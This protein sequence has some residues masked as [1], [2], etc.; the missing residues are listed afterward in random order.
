MATDG[1][2]IIFAEVKTRASRQ[3]GDPLEAID[4]KKIRHLVH[5]ADAY[6][7]CYYV[8]LPFRFDFFSIVIDPQGHEEVE[9]VKDAFYPPLG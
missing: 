3:W 1:Q 5:A 6:M 4:E 2:E 8:D 9:H 7:K